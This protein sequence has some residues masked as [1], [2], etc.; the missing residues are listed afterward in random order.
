MSLPRYVLPPLHHHRVYQ[1]LGLDQ[2]MITT[3]KNITQCKKKTLW[4]KT[5][6]QRHFWILLEMTTRTL[7]WTTSLI[8]T[9]RC[10][11]EIILVTHCYNEQKEYPISRMECRWIIFLQVSYLIVDE[12]DNDMDMEKVV[13]VLTS[14]FCARTWRLGLGEI[15]PEDPNFKIKTCT[16]GF[17]WEIEF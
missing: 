8:A 12:A 7:K 10:F 16:L 2:G 5:R 4:H 14:S 1:L 9:Y 13:I 3:N 17:W 6:L 11:E 15:G